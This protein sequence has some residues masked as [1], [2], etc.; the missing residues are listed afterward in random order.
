MCLICCCEVLSYEQ[1]LFIDRFNVCYTDNLLTVYQRGM[2]VNKF[3]KKL[4]LRFPQLENIA[5]NIEHAY[6]ILKAAYE[7]EN[8]VFICGNGGSASDSEH[9]AGELMKGFI[10]PRKA[11]VEM[12][13]RLKDMYG[14]EGVYMGERLQQ[15]LRTI[16]LNGHPALSSAFSNDVDASMVFAQQ[17]FVMGRPGD[18]LLALSTSGNSNNV[19]KCVQLA[20]AVGV[21]TIAMTGRSGGRCAGLVDCLLNMPEDETYLVQELHLPVYHCLCMMIED[22]FYGE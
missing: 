20:K 6:E 17:L 13:Q 15:G 3:L 16:S 9:I 18:V 5:D 8:T 22:Y 21:K 11:E 7:S 10:L 12:R 1:I 14:E 2:K 19:V 4:I